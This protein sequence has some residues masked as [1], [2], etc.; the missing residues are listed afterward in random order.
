VVVEGQMLRDTLLD[1]RKFTIDATRWPVVVITQHVAQLTD[2][3]RTASLQQTDR[4][5]NDRHGRYAMVLDNR[6]AEPPPAKQRALIAD[7]GVRS[8]ERMRQRCI[9]TAL[10]VSSDVMRAM[11]TAVQWQTGRPANSE[12]FE[13]LSGA[14]AWTEQRLSL[15][16]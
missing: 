4:L 13:D 15:E 14:L 1:P 7:Y 8:A 11:I 9:C 16:R 6:R 10:I 2:E 12:V 3:E 5:L